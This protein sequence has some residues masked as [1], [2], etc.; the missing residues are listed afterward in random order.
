MHNISIWSG[1]RRILGLICRTRVKAAKLVGAHET[2][3]I[4]K[5]RMDINEVLLCDK[6]ECFDI[7]NLKS[8]A[9]SD[10]SLLRVNFPCFMECLEER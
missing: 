9:Y 10:P 2:V 5:R 7:V 6:M 4:L 8:R 3:L 1:E